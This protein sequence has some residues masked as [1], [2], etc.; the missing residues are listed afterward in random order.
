MMARIGL[1]LAPLL[2]L[3]AGPANAQGVSPNQMF[4]CNQAVI[5]DTSASGTTNVVTGTANRRIYV[6][7]FSFW[8]GGTG[9]IGLVYGTGGTC[10]TGQNEVT[11]AFSLTAQTGIVDHLPVYTGLPPVPASNDLCISTG[12]SVA[13]QAIV[14]FTQF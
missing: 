12:T 14:Y 9:T 10:G 7:G 8:S 2:G 11:P 4:G 13:M 3:A 1:F 5:Y 6:C